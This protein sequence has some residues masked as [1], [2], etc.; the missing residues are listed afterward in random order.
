MFFCVLCYE[1]LI[2][3]Y[4]EVCYLLWG[5]VLLIIYIIDELFLL[6]VGW[7]IMDYIFL[8]FISCFYF[9]NIYFELYVIDFLSNM[10]DF[11]VLSVL[12]LKLVWMI[13]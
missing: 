11:V 8:N 7:E 9:E 10:F 2:W 3:Y 12:C 5:Y 13:L 6:L 4:M 1:I